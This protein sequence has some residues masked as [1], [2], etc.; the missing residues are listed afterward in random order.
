VCGSSEIK[1]PSINIQAPEK[2]QLSRSEKKGV[3]NFVT[4]D[5]DLL[6]MLAFECFYLPSLMVLGN[7]VS[8]PLGAFHGRSE[9]FS[10]SEV[11][12]PIKPSSAVSNRP[13]NSQ[14]EWARSPFIS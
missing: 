12:Q 5:L 6:W 11:A 4:M 14:C 2:I 9:R 10:D 13:K 1:D 7:P 3:S 8:H